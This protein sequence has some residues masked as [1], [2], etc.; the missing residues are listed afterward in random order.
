MDTKPSA[1]S[2]FAGF[3]GFGAPNT[4]PVPDV[5]FDVLAPDL[6]EAEL[7]VLLYIIR[8]TFGFKKAADTISLGQMV[9]VLRSG[10]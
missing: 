4:T 5:V 9:H 10:I 8:R 1:H 3:E 2:I 6:G 7:R